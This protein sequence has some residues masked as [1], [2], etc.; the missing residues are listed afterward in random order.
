[1]KQ[2]NHI[3]A[4]SFDFW[5]TLFT[6]QDGGF[7]LYQDTRR[8]LLTR[9]LRELGY[10]VTEAQVAEATLREAES[11]H[12]IWTLE[13]RTLVAADRLRR[14]LNILDVTL[15]DEVFNEVVIAYEEGILER[16]PTLID[17]AFEVVEHLARHYRLGIISDI[18]FSPGRILRE[19][20]RQAGVLEFFESLVFS[21]EAGRSKPHPEVFTQTHRQLAAEPAACVHI[22]D[23]E[24]T[25]IVGA[26][27]AGF[28]SIRFVGV[29]PMLD[30]ERSDAHFVT[31]S[32]RDVPRCIAEIENRLE[33]ELT[34]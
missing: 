33:R 25:D 6:E 24:H 23:L 34:K 11:H 19:V 32:L 27:R 21:D 15:P 26:N 8:R 7:K 22:G 13:H 17:G 5:N 31:T 10:A 30:G 28:Y 14:V 9:A 16:P 29:T 4:I 18:G 1:M 20:M 3:K 12:L 2:A